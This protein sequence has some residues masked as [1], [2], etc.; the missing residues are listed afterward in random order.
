MTAKARPS[1][2][3]LAQT[4]S[5]TKNSTNSLSITKSPGCSATA[6]STILRTLRSSLNSRGASG[7]IGVKSPGR[8]DPLEGEARRGGVG[9]AAA[10]AAAAADA[11]AADADDDDA[12]PPEP[13]AGQAA[14]AE[15]PG[16]KYFA[17]RS[18]SFFTAAFRGSPLSVPSME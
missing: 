12:P 11:D 2:R 9:A 13:P 17:L 4:P 10:A 3:L 1:R 6:D 16:V 14:A 8:D 15:D 7:F 18:T 5:P